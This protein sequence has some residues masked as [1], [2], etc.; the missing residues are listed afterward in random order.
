MFLII[1]SFRQH[2][3]YFRPM[4]FLATLKSSEKQEFAHRNCSWELFLGVYKHVFVNWVDIY[5]AKHKVSH[6]ETKLSYLKSNLFLYC[7]ID[8][9]E[10]SKHS[11][12]NQDTCNMDDRIFK[13]TDQKLFPNKRN[14]NH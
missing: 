3:T 10:C 6:I 12:E 1:L 14:W 2:S 7:A 9:K 4:Y 11:N 8:V 5:Y 13:N